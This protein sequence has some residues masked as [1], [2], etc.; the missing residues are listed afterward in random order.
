MIFFSVFR[1][2][3]LVLIFLLILVSCDKEDT[4]QGGD[5]DPLYSPSAADDARHELTNLNSFEWWYFDATF[6]NKYSIVTSWHRGI[7]AFTPLIGIPYNLILFAVYDSV[8]TASIIPAIFEEKDVIISDKSCDVTMG[9]NHVYGNYPTY[10]I[11]FLQGGLGCDL[12]F[13]NMTQGYRSSPDGIYKF[14]QDPYRYLGWV[15]AQPRATVSGT[16]FYNG[17][18]I[19]VTGNG[20][21]DHNWGNVPLKSLYNFWYWGRI[22]LKGYTFVYSSGEM[23]DGLG[24]QPTNT[25]ISFKDK[26]VIEVTG[27]ISRETLDMNYDPFSTLW[28]P[29]R[30]KLTISGQKVSGVFDIQLIKILEHIGMP[31]DTSQVGHGYIRFL[32][33][34]Y[35]DLLVEGQAVKETDTVIHELMKP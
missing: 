8:G 14:G 31:W 7:Q 4:D 33:V 32:S 25:L 22:L 21:H 13:T 2:L 23:S 3:I 9:P 12:V 1:R 20:Y 19:P 10:R 18:E 6:D 34:C 27:A 11:H 16:L 26:K 30:L 35:S 5:V 28:Y 24:H 15:V 29:E 17:R